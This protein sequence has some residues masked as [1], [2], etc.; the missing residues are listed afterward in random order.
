MKRN[1]SVLVFGAI[2]LATSLR[3]AAQTTT[4]SADVMKD[5]KAQKETMMSIAAAM[6]EE[7]FGYKSTPA[8]RSW[9]E[10]ILHVAGGNIFLM[11]FLGGKAPAP[12]VNTAD[13]VVF[14]LKASTKAEYL[15]ALGDSFDYGEA[16]LKEFSDTSLTET[17]KGPPW[18]GPSTRVRMLYDAI[19]HC[20]DIYGQ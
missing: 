5:W 2:V 7:K 11:R 19:A 13:M 17:I 20:Q 6:P 4:L 16:V 18:M 1:V 9:G 12:A 8:Q 15:K 3:P 10:Q 14:G